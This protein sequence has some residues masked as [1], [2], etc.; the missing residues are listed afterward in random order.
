MNLRIPGPTPVPEE[1]AQAGAAEMIDHRGPEFAAL[2]ERVTV[3]VKEV[4]QTQNDLVVLTTSGS[5]AME[6]AVVNHISPG[7][8]V[9]VI[10]IGEFGKR[11]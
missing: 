6:S 5:G 2:I 1:V 8:Q 7:E 9:L 4:F 3:G 10:T 11:S